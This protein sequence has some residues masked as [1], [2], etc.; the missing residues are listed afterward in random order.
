MVF[1]LEKGG[2]NQV[3]RGGTHLFIDQDFYFNYMDR[4]LVVS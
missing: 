4:S 1:A 3:P 2:N